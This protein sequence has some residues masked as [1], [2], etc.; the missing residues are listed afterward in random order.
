MN[1]KIGENKVPKIDTKISVGNIITMALV[2]FGGLATWFGVVSKVE[3][4]ETLSTN[5]QIAIE[6][7]EQKTDSLDVIEHKIDTALKSLE[8]LEAQ[9]RP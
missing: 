9:P 4:N 6:V 3:A 5:N 1:F 2:L 8:R 7:I